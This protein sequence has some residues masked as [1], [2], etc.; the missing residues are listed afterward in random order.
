MDL[1]SASKNTIVFGENAYQN[2]NNFLLEQDFSK[3]FL[4][5]DEN[6]QNQC[7]PYFL[8]QLSTP[9]NL[10]IIEIESGEDHKNI[11]TCEQ[12]WSI[13]S[14]FNGDRK[15]VLINLG[16]GVLTDMGGFVA[17]TFLRGIPF[18]NVPT[19]LLAMVDAS[20]GGKTGVNREGIKNQIG[21]FKE[22]VLTLI[23]V[24]YLAT[25]PQNQMK[26][27]LAEMLK[28][29]LIIDEAY[30]RK[31]TDLS[32]LDLSDL[33]ELVKHS[34]ELKLYVTQK[35]QTEMGLR[36]ILNFGHTLGHAIESYFLEKNPEEALLHGEAIAVGMILE[37]YISHQISGLHK[38]ELIDITR[39]IQTTFSK[40][41]FPPEAIDSILAYLK[42]DKKNAHGKV[43]FVLL[44]KIGQAIF[45]QA[46]S[47][48]LI[49]E[50]FDYYH[51]L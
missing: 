24:S 30:W 47:E 6:T 35:D 39:V 4:L 7:V 11:S 44:K 25:L 34:I 22:A 18:I 50:A 1:N 13:L 5:C 17:S 31:L 41:D 26:S 15:S 21:L 32:K 27:G 20:V 19:T 51:Q 10:E 38:Q 40:V 48:N 42:F 43:Q 9:V 36:K 45:D 37:A 2:L 12:L 33:E 29:G 23:D 8:Q 14:E 28:H 46:V 3:V 16:G 49:R